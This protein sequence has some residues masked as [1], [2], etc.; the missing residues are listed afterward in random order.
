MRALISQEIMY[1]WPRWVEVCTFV[2]HFLLATG[3]SVNIL[4][5][6][7]CDKRFFVVVQKTLR[8][9]FVWPIT[10]MERGAITLSYLKLLTVNRVCIQ[11]KSAKYEPRVSFLGLSRHAS[12]F[13]NNRYLV[14][15]LKSHSLVHFPKSHSFQVSIAY[16]KTF[17]CLP[18]NFC[19]VLHEY[20]TGKYL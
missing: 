20:L 1:Q 18:T 2:S 7:S 16:S 3:A 17:F 19:E 14:H 8:A 13:I 12:I 9:W 10:I 5:Y 11:F 4:L 6:C 15:F